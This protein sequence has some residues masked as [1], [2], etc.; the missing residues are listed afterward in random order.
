MS[1]IVK[2]INWDTETVLAEFDLTPQGGI[3][4]IY[5]SDSFRQIAERD[6]FYLPGKGV[7]H[8]DD[9]Q[10]FLDAIV[11]EYANSSRMD[12]V[13]TTV[14]K[15]RQDAY[16]PKK[17]AAPDPNTPPQPNVLNGDAVEAGATGPDLYG[18]PLV[19][20]KVAKKIKSARKHASTNPTK[21]PPG[22]SHDA[23]GEVVPAKTRKKK[24]KAAPPV[25]GPMHSDRDDE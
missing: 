10:D 4:A 5:H 7:K 8:I 12:V 1:L 23:P 18:R 16:D 21:A 22:L 9:G 20:G 6:G 2:A 17:A 13:D 24:P 3:H 25:P 14:G 15:S 11:A 19:P